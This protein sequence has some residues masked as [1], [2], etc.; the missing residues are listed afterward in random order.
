[1]CAGQTSPAKTTIL[2]RQQQQPNF[3]C[4]N[5]RGQ[6]L[7]QTTYDPTIPCWMQGECIGS[8]SGRRT[9]CERLIG[10]RRCSS[11]CFRHSRES[12][13]LLNDA[14]QLDQLIQERQCGLRNCGRKIKDCSSCKELTVRFDC[15]RSS[16]VFRKF[17]LD[18]CW[19]RMRFIMMHIDG[20]RNRCSGMGY[21][22]STV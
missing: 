19:Q 18:C 17:Q 15:G 8:W 16:A 20:T 13:L 11:S 14:I 12:K 2:M 9:I 6:G 22:L 3:K 21:P 7:E 1:M 4:Q 10:W 5:D